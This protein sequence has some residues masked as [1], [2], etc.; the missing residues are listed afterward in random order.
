[1]PRPKTRRLLFDCGVLLAGVTLQKVH[2]VHRDVEAVDVVGGFVR[3]HL[4]QLL[5]CV[6][7]VR[8]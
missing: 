8:G 2:R 7:D 1:V 5:S 3:V 4:V 6:E